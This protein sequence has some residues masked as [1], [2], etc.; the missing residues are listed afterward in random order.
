MG[1]MER[2]KSISQIAEMTGFDRRTVKDRIQNLVVQK[3]H[4]KAQYFDMFEVLPKLYKL[5]SVGDNEN[6]DDEIKVETLRLERAK[7][8]KTELEVA[9][10]KGEQVPI[11][12]V[13]KIVE[14]EYT[15][16]RAQLIAIPTKI[17]HELAIM[18]DPILIKEKLED[19]INEALSELSA[20]QKFNENEIPDIE[21]EEVEESTSLE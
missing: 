14:S 11:K 13:A 7:A 19:S 5:T 17:F 3:T 10:I 2:Y 16:V 8:D 21:N 1:Y 6:I 12:D 9:R 15:S 20:D 4:G 18:D